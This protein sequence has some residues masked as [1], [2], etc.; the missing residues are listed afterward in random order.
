MAPLSPRSVRRRMALLFGL[1]LGAVAAAFFH[2]PLPQDPAYHAFAD[3]RTLLGVPDFWNVATNLAFLPVGLW[4]LWALGRTPGPRFHDPLEA[5]PYRV[6]SGGALLVAVGSGFYHLA[7]DNLRLVWDRLPMTVVFMAL[8]SAVVAER[9]NV[10][11]GAALLPPL[12]VLGV[13]SV[14]VWRQ[15]EL[16][17]HGDLRLYALVQF[18]P[19]VAIP[20]IVLMFPARYDLSGGFGW[21][22]AWYALAKVLE[23]WDAAV[24]RFTGGLMSGHALK[25]LAAAAALAS[26]IPMLAHRRPLEPGLE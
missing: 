13:A 22:V 19:M 1:F 21:M 16:A 4:G 7:P 8:L 25:H 23:H 11:S 15:G 12:L 5:R 14:L 9:I 24:F 26:L 10:R 17:G 18:F 2:A 20:L 6:V 3:G